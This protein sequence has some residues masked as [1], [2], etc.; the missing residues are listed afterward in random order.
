MLIEFKWMAKSDD[1]KLEWKT[2][3]R[4]VEDFQDCDKDD[5]FDWDSSD[6]HCPKRAF[7]GNYELLQKDIW[8]WL[9]R[10]QPTGGGHWQAQHN[11]AIKGGQAARHARLNPKAHLLAK[12]SQKDQKNNQRPVLLHRPLVPL[13]RFYKFE[14]RTWRP[15]LLRRAPKTLVLTNQGRLKIVCRCSQGVKGGRFVRSA[16]LHEK[17]VQ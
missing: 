16:A 1:V 2:E 5:S 7:E 14:L 11:L 12:Y 10:R 9:G 15:S 3:H 17:C 8:V 13:Q 4:V 6:L